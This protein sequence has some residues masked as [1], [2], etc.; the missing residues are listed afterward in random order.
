L[1]ACFAGQAKGQ[2]RP[3]PLSPGKGLEPRD[4]PE[5]GRVSWTGSV[6]QIQRI[7]RAL[8]LLV[9]GRGCKQQGTKYGENRCGCGVFMGKYMTPAP[10]KRA[11]ITKII[12][13]YE[14][15]IVISVLK[16]YIYINNCSLFKK[17]FGGW[18]FRRVNAGGSGFAGHKRTLF[19]SKGKFF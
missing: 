19:L 14:K 12:R 11:D 13:I 4:Y 7:S 10:S 3:L 5:L 15:L 18:S 6:L 8:F 17:R 16:V 1:R 2:P 9:L